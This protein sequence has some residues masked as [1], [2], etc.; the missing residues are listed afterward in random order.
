MFSSMAK[1][2]RPVAKI[3]LSD[4]ERKKLEL[5]A[6]RPSSSLREA[7][8]ARIILGCAEGCSNSEVAQREK[9]SLPTVGKWRSRFAKARLEALVDAPRSGAPRSISDDKVEAVVTKTLEQ[10]PEARTHW[11]S[12]SMAKASGISD[13]S[14]RRIW[15][16]FGLKPHLVEGFKLSTDPMFVEKVRDIVGLYLNPP[17]K[18]IVLCVDEKSQT[19]ALERTQPILPLRPDIPER[20]SWDYERHGTLSLFAAYD[21]ATGRV[22]GK[23]RNRHRS[24]E[25]L[26]FLKEI[27]QNWPDDGRDLHIIMDNY[28]THKTEKIRRWFGRHPRFKVHFTPTGASWINMVERFFAKITTEA[29]RR[30]S[31]RSTAQLK[32]AMD[33]YIQVHNR[34]PKPFKWT[35]SADTIFKKIEN[36]CF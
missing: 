36:A 5:M 7:F 31:F 19:Q 30:G 23:S 33:H 25:F 12:R 16:A 3:E 9:T 26:L 1:T 35:A 32:E 14:V 27:D 34:D 6:N 10:K 11:T 8:R 18:A 20:Q 4:F 2:G 22:L 24:E 21:T 28:A 13:H 17:E 15:R 29:I